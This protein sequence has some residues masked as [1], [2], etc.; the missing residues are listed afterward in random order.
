MSHD[1][2]AEALVGQNIRAYAKRASIYN[3]IHGEIF[4]PK[5]QRRLRETVTRA[6]A[7][8]TST[9]T[10]AL[11]FGTGTG[12][13]T[14]HMLDIGFQVTAADLSPQFLQIVEERYNIPTI[15]LIGGSLAHLPDSSYDLIGAYSVMHH[16][17]DYLGAIAK[18]IT[19]LRPG[20]VL[21]IDHEHND[22]YWHPTPELIDFRRENAEAR[23]GRFW[24]PDH[25]RLQYLLRAAMTPRR[26][27]ARL[28]RR[29]RIS[30]EGDIHVYADDHIEWDR[31]LDLLQDTGAELVERV[32]YLLFNDSTFALLAR[33]T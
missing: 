33:L 18:L 13:V 6:S 24:D 2:S 32:D 28:R 22:T 31:I 10:Q 29:L 4:N 20:G 23:T 26:H 7:A 11:D 16:I 8:I 19:K 17:P 21:L 14:E 25:K 1:H 3:A 15:Q 12:N 30:D 5:E 27:L 9:G